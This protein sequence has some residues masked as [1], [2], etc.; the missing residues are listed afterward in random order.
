MLDQKSVRLQHVKEIL[1]TMNSRF[2]IINES[3]MWIDGREWYI[4]LPDKK[5]NLVYVHFDH[6]IE[7]GHAADLA[8]RFGIVAGLLGLEVHPGCD[9][10]SDS[11]KSDARLITS[12]KKD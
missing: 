9:I 4:W 8:L 7:N 10:C 3:K 12:V 6:R 5:P 2:E 11:T 1:R